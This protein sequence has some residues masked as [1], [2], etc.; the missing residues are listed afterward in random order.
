M[1]SD[2]VSE[3]PCSK[4][5]STEG[6]FRTRKKR[7]KIVRRSWCNACELVAH[8]EREAAPDRQATRAAYR[9]TEQRAASIRRYARS[10]K[11]IARLRTYSAAWRKANPDKIDAQSA[12]NHAIEAGRI[13]R[14]PCSQCGAAK[15]DAHHHR[16]YQR[17]HWFDV[18]W[19]CRSCHK[20]EHAKERRGR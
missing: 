9:R 15:A 10:E 8:R 20:L 2:T 13:A 18:V 1:D 19:L 14:Q 12:L 4:C 17:E 3:R 16:G 5:G 11:G 7:G 6:P